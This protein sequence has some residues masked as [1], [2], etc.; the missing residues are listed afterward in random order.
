M[1]LHRLYRRSIDFAERRA[2]LQSAHTRPKPIGDLVALSSCTSFV[3]RYC[4]FL[5]GCVTR[6]RF[7]KVFRASSSGVDINSSS[8]D[9][10]AATLDIAR[11]AGKK[12]REMSDSDKAVSSTQ[13]SILHLVLILS[14]LQ[15][16][17]KESNEAMAKYKAAHT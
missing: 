6:D 17:I 8:T 4:E 15:P 10:R 1:Y 12:W 11:Q 16:Y 3:C 7:L 13:S 5:T 14:L 9:R 2:S